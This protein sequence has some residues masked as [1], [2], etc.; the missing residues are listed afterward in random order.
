MNA[1]VEISA[2]KCYV[3]VVSKTSE[4]E[5]HKSR[6]RGREV[7]QDCCVLGEVSSRLKGADSHLQVL[8]IVTVPHFFHF[9]KTWDSKYHFKGWLYYLQ[10][11]F[12]LQQGIHKAGK[13]KVQWLN[14]GEN[15]YNLILVTFF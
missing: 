6:D 12:K 9:L 1:G 7:V 2:G 10:L 3:S 14:W 13:E 15:K 8:V 11:S 5:N 4:G